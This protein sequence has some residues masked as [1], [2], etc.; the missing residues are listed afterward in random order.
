LPSDVTVLGG[1]TICSGNVLT[2]TASNGGDGTIYFQGTTSGGISTLNPSTS[3][4][5]SSAGTYYF[6]V[7]SAQGC[8]GSEDSETVI[9]A[10]LPST[11][12]ANGD[13]TFCENTTITAAGGAGGIIYFQGTTSN[14]T[15]TVLPS[16][17]EVITSTGTYYFRA[18]STEGCWGPEGSVTVTINPLPAVDAGPDVY[19]C[20]GS[21]VV[22]MA[23]GAATFSWNNGV[24]NGLPFIANSS[25]TN[26]VTGTSVNGCVS[27]DTVQVLTSNFIYPLIST[28]ASAS[29]L[30]DG[31]GLVT[32]DP[33][34]NFSII[35]STGSQGSTATSLCPGAVSV[36]I[37]ELDFG[38]QYQLNA[39]VEETSA[40]YPLSTQLSVNDASFDGLC[41]GSAEFFAFGGV[42]PYGLS[43][44]NENNTLIS[45]GSIASGLCSGIYTV[46]L[47]DAVGSTDTSSFYIA[48][49][50]NIYSTNTYADS[51]IVDTLI[52][53]VVEDCTIDFATIDS[54]WVSELTYLN[55]DTANVTWSVQDINGVYLIQQQYVI[56]NL[57]GTFAIEL[58]LF[59][60]GKAP[61]DPFIKLYGEVYINTSFLGLVSWD[62]DL[63]N[64]YIYPNPTADVI[65]ILLPSDKL[66]PYIL[67]D[68]RGRKVLEGTLKASESQLT[69]KELTPGL[70]VLCFEEEALQIRVIKQ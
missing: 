12:V 70:Y 14:G 5:I 34:G 41:D 1:A 23:G 51:M 31:T 48:E 13:G 57:N 4:V 15:S 63:G 68:D 66:R 53:D 2:L 24:Q 10:S 44:Y 36:N 3:E 32:V 6:R 35:W 22:L 7:Q 9:V 55:Q 69:L 62:E 47:T 26:V 65:N 49:P 18:Q 39:F 16:T 40:I 17:S 21:S 42:S 54:V 27:T 38:C 37:T 19:V 60:P 59:C 28:T 52:V 56:T 43:L 25:S 58:V 20:S 67:V 11:V 8:W 64:N 46:V 61:G 33:S 29:N 50:S 30:C 45:S